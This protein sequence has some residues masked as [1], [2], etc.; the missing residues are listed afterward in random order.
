MCILTSDIKINFNKQ[1]GAKKMEKKELTS[2]VRNLKV[3]EST[4]KINGNH[5][6]RTGKDSWDCYQSGLYIA[7]YNY[8]KDVSKWILLRSITLFEKTELIFFSFSQHHF[9]NI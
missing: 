6:K 9:H 8:P 5:A 2:I 1:I 7:T 4:P 3:G